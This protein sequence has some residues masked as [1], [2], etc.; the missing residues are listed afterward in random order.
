MA[1]YL[2]RPAWIGLVLCGLTL[3]GSAATDDTIVPTERA[4][5]VEKTNGPLLTR[6]AKDVTPDR[7]LPEYP[8]PQM[9]RPRW[10][11]LNGL[12]DYA[13]TAREAP[14]RAHGMEESWSR[15]PSSRRSR[16]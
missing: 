14:R 3:E 16:A 1:L 11:N 7:A 2:A 15:S 13:V 4:A 5:R 10:L 8:R 9:V 12:W 6:W